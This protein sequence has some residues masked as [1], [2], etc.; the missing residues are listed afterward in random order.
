MESDGGG[1]GRPTP[2]GDGIDEDKDPGEGSGFIASASHM[3][4]T[5]RALAIAAMVILGVLAAGGL[6]GWLVILCTDG[7][8]Q[9]MQ[10][11]AVIFSPVVALIG[12]IL[13]FYFSKSSD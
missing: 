4:K 9:Q 13:G 2:D 5:R 12:P 3:D 7:S 1:G 11:F 10:A 8:V 6:G